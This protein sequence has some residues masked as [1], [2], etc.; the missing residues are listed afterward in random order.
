M[1]SQMF[2][3][4]DRIVETFAPPFVA[5]TTAEAERMFVTAAADEKSQLHQ[6]PND[7]AL[8]HIGTF[9]NATGMVEAIVP[10]RYLRSAATIEAIQPREKQ[11]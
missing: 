10:A 7:F 2:A 4:H 5:Q 3:V 11:S 8:Y 6:H 9:N 1:K